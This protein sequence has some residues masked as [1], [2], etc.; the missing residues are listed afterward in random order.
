MLFASRH[1]FDTVVCVRFHPFC[2]IR[3]QR[4][5]VTYNF[6]LRVWLLFVAPPPSSIPYSAHLVDGEAANLGDPLH[7]TIEFSQISVRRAYG[8]LRVD[9]NLTAG[10]EKQGIGVSLSVICC[11]RNMWTCRRRSMQQRMCFERCSVSNRE[12]ESRQMSFS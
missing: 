8:E 12:H 5:L 11:W 4:F 2:F 7:R 1:H 10:G 9:G 6:H 3:W